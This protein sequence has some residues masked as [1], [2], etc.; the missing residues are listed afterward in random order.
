MPELFSFARGGRRKLA[1]LT[2]T[3]GAPT[4]IWA[5]ADGAL[6]TVCDGEVVAGPVQACAVLANAR[7]IAL[8]VSP[9]LQTANEMAL[10]LLAL[11]AKE[12]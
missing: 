6:M 4:E 12:A 1:T 5:E 8:G 11:Q 9:S 7:A 3:P 10:V 2:D